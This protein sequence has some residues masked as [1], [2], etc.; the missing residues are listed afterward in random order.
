MG[1]EA[2]LAGIS[3]R[4]GQ[5]NLLTKLV[6]EHTT[7]KRAVQIEVS[8]ERRR[9]VGEGPHQVRRESELR[10][11]S[12]KQTPGRAGCGSGIDGGNAGHVISFVHSPA[13]AS[14]QK[15]H[16]MPSRNAANRAR[17]RGIA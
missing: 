9:G 16:E 14:I 2:V 6:I 7:R 3:L 11:N 17:R 1:G 5:R 15:A 12:V 4:D 10:L 8:L 13:V